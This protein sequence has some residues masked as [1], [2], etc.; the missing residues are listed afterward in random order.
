MTLAIGSP[1]PEFEMRSTTGELVKLSDFKGKQNVLLV[2]YPWAF[3]RVCTSE[4]C[5]LNND[6]PDIVSDEVAVFGVSTDSVPTL[7]AWKKAEGFQN[8]FLSDFWPHGKAS[9][10]Y[11]VFV[12]GAGV[13]NRGTFL[14]DKEGIL[15]WKETG[16]IGEARDQGTWREALTDLGVA[17]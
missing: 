17:V 10:D 8:E 12:D 9:S 11:G 6:N 15:R 2:F 1:A 5:T 4:F 7:R 3:T 14:I 13:A 16:E